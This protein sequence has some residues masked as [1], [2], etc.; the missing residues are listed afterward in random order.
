MLAS[1]FSNL[2]YN[3]TNEAQCSRAPLFKG[4]NIFFG[5]TY[6][7]VVTRYVKELL[8]GGLDKIMNK[9][10]QQSYE[11]IDLFIYLIYKLNT[12]F[13]LCL[14]LLNRTD[15]TFLESKLSLDVI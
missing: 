15:G 8:I 2:E 1:L 11:I 10:H 9:S 13:F 5:S 12:Y 6:I 14:N 3:F 4:S 7:V